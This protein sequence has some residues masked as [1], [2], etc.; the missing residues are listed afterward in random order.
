M[1]DITRQI[2]AERDDPPAKTMPKATIAADAPSAS[3]HQLCGLKKP[4]LAGTVGDLA[5]GVV[6]GRRVDPTVGEQQVVSR[7]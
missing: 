2:S 4:E 7:S 6:L 5:V 3:G 1:I